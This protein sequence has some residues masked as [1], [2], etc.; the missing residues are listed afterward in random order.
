M[1]G[2]IIG[3]A[4]ALVVAS[5]AAAG[6]LYRCTGRDVVAAEE[7]GTVGRTNRDFWLG[8]YRSF[9]VDT[10]T[11]SIRWSSGKLEEWL[12]TQKG[13]SSNDFVATPR[14]SLS[15]A[16]TDFIRVT[17]WERRP[18]VTFLVFRLS[19]MITGTCEVAQ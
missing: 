16:S 19:M 13:G 10:D 18:S 12:V 9:F 3:L 1:K 8:Y 6:K 4:A 5:P 14:S 15:G 7:D 17:G 11:G 2:A